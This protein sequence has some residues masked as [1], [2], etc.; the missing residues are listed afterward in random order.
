MTEVLAPTINR[1]LGRERR[2]YAILPVFP[3]RRLV[4][5]PN[6]LM[7]IDKLIT[8]G[9]AFGP[10]S[11]RTT[12]TRRTFPDVATVAPLN[13]TRQLSDVQETGIEKPRF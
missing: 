9:G 8:G 12:L 3:G 11:S 5:K 1:S 6:H 10:K 7:T 13:T 2:R 4:S